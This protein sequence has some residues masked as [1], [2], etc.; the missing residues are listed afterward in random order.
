MKNIYTFLFALLITGLGFAQTSPGDIAFTAFNAD[1]GDDFAIVALVDI[2]ANTEIYFTDNEPASATTL[3]GGEGTL[4]WNSGGSL[5]TQGSI[6][7]FTDASSGSRSA[8]IGSFSSAGGSFNLAGGGDAL[9]AFV[10]TSATA[11]TGWLAGIQ[12]EANNQGGGFASSGLTVGTT[13]INFYT[14]GSPDGGYYSGPRSG[15]SLFSDYLV[16][17][18]DNSNWTRE[19]SS[20]E[21]ILPIS[22][23]AFTI[24]GGCTAPTTQ[25]SAYNTTA[26]GSSFA[27][28][29]WTSGDGDEVLVLVKAGS[30]VDTDPTNGTSYTGN[31][32]FG[33]GDEIGTGNYAVYT[34]T[35]SSSASITGLTPSTTYHVA[36]YEYNTTDTCYLTPALT[37]NFTTA[38]VTTV[39]FST[40]SAS[41]SENIGT[42]DLVVQI[43]NEDA[44]NAT[45]FDVVLTSGDASDIDSYVTQSESF[46]GGSVTDINITITVTDDAVFEADEVLTFEIQNVTG[47]NNAIV[48]TNNTFNLTITNDDL[49]APIALPYSEDFSDC[50]AAEWFTFDQTGNDSWLCGS[51]EYAINGFSGSDDIDWLISD[52][53]ID[54]DAYSNETIEIETSERYG[55]TTN[56]VGEFELLYSTDY[57]GS[58]DPTLATWTAL[59]FDPNNSS[60]GSGLSTASTTSVD[61]SGISGIAYLAFKYDMTA[62][63]GAEDWRVLDISITE[64]AAPNDADTEVF[65]VSQVAG[66][67][68]IAADVTTSGTAFDVLS[69][70]VDDQGTSDGL[71]TNI[72]R[73]RFV[74]GPNN[75]ADWTDFIQG[76]TV[77]DGNVT[78]HTPSTTITD[79]ELILDFA[80][81]IAVADGTTL[82]FLIGLYLNTTNIVDGNIIQLQI[83][84]TSSGFD[85]DANGSD[86]VD[87][88]LFGDVVGNNFTVDVDATTLSFIQQPSDV[89]VDAVMSPDVTVAYV[90]VNGNVDPD[91]DGL[92][93]ISLSTT[94]SFDISA[95]TT[96][97]AS[98]GIATFNNLVFDTEDTGISL[99]ATDDS[100]IIPGS[101][102]SDSFDVTPLPTGATD[103]IFSEYI[104]GSSNNKYIEIYNGTGATVTLSNYTV[105]LYSNGSGSASNT[106]D[107]SV[108][109][110]ATLADGAVIVLQNSSA[111]IYGGTAYSTSV[112]NFNG[113]DTIVLKN[114]GTIIDI[115]GNIGCDPGS[116]WSD[117]GNTTSNMTLVRNSNVCSGVSADPSNSPCD[118]PTLAT[119]WSNSSIDTVTNL[120][121]H[122]ANCGTP[123]TTTYT[124]DG[125]WS[126]SDPSGT[127]TASDDIVIESG[128]A[129]IN[130]N[131]TCNTVTVNAGAGLTVDT[132]ITLTTNTLTLESSS[133][134][135][136]SLILDGNVIGDIYYERHVN[137]NGSGDTGSNDLISAPL[138][139]QAFNNFA[140]ANPNI[141]NNG[142]L[143]LFGPFEKSTGEYLTWAGTETSTLDAGVG[144]R[145][146]T[147]D[148]GTV[149]FTGTANNSTITYNIT[150]SGPQEAE[151]NLVGNPYPS[152]MNVHSFFNHEVGSGVTNL[153]LFNT[154][155]GAIYGYDGTA[156]DGWIIYNMATTTLSTVIAPGQGFFV[157]ADASSVAAYDLEFT[158]AMRSTGT[159]DD[160]ISGR[161]AELVFV[162]VNART[163]SNSYT[164]DFYFNSNASSAFDFGYDAEV[165][166]GT[167]PDFAIYSHLVDN[168][169]GK[170]MALQSL[171]ASD[172]SNVTI[173]LGVH[174]NQG[175][176]LTFSIAES[177]LSESVKVYL[178]DVV[179]NTSTLLNASDY[180]ITPSSDLS[181][182]G[183]FF[184]RTS[185]EALSTIEH[186]I[187]ALNIYALNNSKALVISGQLQ[188]NAH[189]SLYDIQGRKVL[190]KQLD[191]TRL[192]NRVDASV[193]S[194]G[195]Y[196]VTVENN[197][198][199]E[200]QKVILK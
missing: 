1:G 171:H 179:A 13:F 115:I 97:T 41:V 49:A 27:T 105:E 125:T 94:G 82:D 60:S 2:P 114:N 100:T 147:T 135:Y 192:E 150:N 160:F 22:T 34:G 87:P 24:S 3:T 152:Y 141:L 134:S 98:N 149:T 110:P 15:E 16:E 180:V 123:V 104:E 71:A 165:W 132:A 10:G 8:S 101:F 59:T 157:S 4:L 112:C 69:F 184:L 20:G 144:Y 64:S 172:L 99:T 164:T 65:A 42:Y 93:D 154:G 181:G 168:N 167:T 57:T 26:I 70:E 78:S 155:T 116:S 193:L 198:Q 177:T 83:D 169:Q 89:T 139:G 68:V 45:N 47:G 138:T 137:I 5:I 182:T 194:E 17:L 48:G 46:P 142:T 121:S 145:A 28:L 91:Y 140:T 106:E 51:G 73:M 162:K 190:T 158:P 151:W 136:S 37:G 18:G 85:A 161:N 128:N 44:I 81:P 159:S 199:Q 119:E 74:P 61:A 103:L 38:A 122:T 9:Y 95:T 52:F 75:T 50:A 189:L 117:S 187:D 185:N 120:G 76:V 188:D 127:A 196:V 88:F 197:G 173:P 53:R 84:G 36:V 200:T 156:Q 131:T 195:V 163:N 86:F 107:F 39:E 166:G 178:D 109:F 23:T 40:T 54:F 90:D 96:V 126:P 14:S 129:T 143:Y 102:V 153:D 21:N 146:G 80:A 12:N 79:T 55:N 19:T 111:S 113:D 92:F 67:I 62:G 29:N 6:I 186:N 32:A 63:A 43:S 11:V 33:S 30:A 56:E 170:A 191:S 118:F 31:T 66:D 108:G 174:A 175:E 35:T 183:R 25:A 7:V 176:Q 124:F 77:L 72:T 133:T 130:T 58:G 148:N